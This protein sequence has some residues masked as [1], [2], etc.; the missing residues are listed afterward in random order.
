[1]LVIVITIML[2]MQVSTPRPM[3]VDMRIDLRVDMR[4]RGIALGVVL[5]TGGLFLAT[6]R[7]TPTAN[8][9]GLD[10]VGGVASERR[11]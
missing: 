3:R 4:H 10:R 11:R 5:R 2:L 9:E 6:L 8:A 7:R 1:M